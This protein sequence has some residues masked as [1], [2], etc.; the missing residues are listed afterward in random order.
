MLW[1][2]YEIEWARKSS[3]IKSRSVR[4]L[5]KD[6]KNLLD[7]VISGLIIVDKDTKDNLFCN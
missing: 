2:A 5:N 3:F 6:Y 1:I 7:Q 4:S